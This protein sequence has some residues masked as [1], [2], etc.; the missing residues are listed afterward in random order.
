MENLR[1]NSFRIKLLVLLM[2][3]AMLIGVVFNFNR[4]AVTNNVNAVSFD[5]TTSYVSVGELFDSDT[6]QFS[7]INYQ[8]LK[9][10]LAGKVDATASDIDNLKSLGGNFGSSLIRQQT[11]DAGSY[12]GVDYLAKSNTQDIVVRLGGLDWQVVYL[13]RD[14]SDNSILTLWLD[15]C[16]QDAWTSRS[17]TEGQNYGFINGGLYSD[18]SNGITSDYTLDPDYPVNMYGTSYI[19]AVV[20]NN[21]GKCA[22]SSSQVTTITK[23]TS[24]AFALYTM[25]QYGLTDYLV[26]PMQVEWQEYQSAID[27]LD[28]S[29]CYSNDAWSK[30]AVS[31]NSFP[32]SS[33]YY[34]DK[35]YSDAWAG[36]YLW[37]PSIT[38]VGDG[39][40][41]LWNL[42]TTQ[43]ENYDGTDEPMI[44]EVGVNVSSAY[45]ETWLRSAASI[46]AD[47]E[48]PDEISCSLS[49]SGT[50][51]LYYGVWNSLAVRPALHLNLNAVETSVNRV[52]ITDGSMSVTTSVFDGSEKDLTITV[53]GRPLSL[54]T[55]YTVSYKM[56]GESVSKLWDAGTYTITA[57]GIGNYYGELTKTF[58]INPASL[59]G[60]TL[61]STSETYCTPNIPP[62]VTVSA[63]YGFD[64][65][66]EGED[67]ELTYKNSVG[68][69]ITAPQMVNAGTY[70]IIATG[71]GNFTGEVSAT[72]TIEPKEI[73]YAS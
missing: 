26:T 25:E 28:R 17:A 50:R 72:F 14:K 4:T 27:E 57:T 24:S 31:E 48:T 44:G 42:S 8:I 71:I 49:A 45:S 30:T 65:L 46:G 13:S 33:Y 20:L 3:L 41:G 40:G 67:F 22:T 69:T 73:P 19:N 38:E 59:Y 15:N 60:I 52:S 39:Y 35:E 21:G 1:V 56:N 11:L 29:Y 7:K 12:N 66:T 43:L 37:L 18:Y 34:G 63:D 16:V 64:A 32:D 10:Y 61:S 70:T 23:S 47:A 2:S 58:T 53:D 9:N 62:A 54:D 51:I 68:D 36:S 55:D 5:D 6:S